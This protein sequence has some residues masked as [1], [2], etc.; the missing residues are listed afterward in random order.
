VTAVA[1]GPGACKIAVEVGVGC[2]RQVP[3]GKGPLA[4]GRGRPANAAAKVCSER[5]SSPVMS[6][7]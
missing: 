5:F 7:M 2:T 1:A 3:V 6:A 4:G